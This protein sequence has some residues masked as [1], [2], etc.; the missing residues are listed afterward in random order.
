[1]DTAGAAPAHGTGQMRQPTQCVNPRFPESRNRENARGKV[2]LAVA[3]LPMG[4]TRGSSH[5]SGERNCLSW[6]GFGVKNT[7]VGT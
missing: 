2:L 3:R 4:A 5:A 7:Q 1:V 6:R